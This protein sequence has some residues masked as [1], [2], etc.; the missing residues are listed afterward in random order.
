MENTGNVLTLH[1][2]CFTFQERLIS[3]PFEILATFTKEHKGM[4]VIGTGYA[5]SKHESL[6]ITKLN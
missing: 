5:N 6:F 4:G 2:E 3:M 1:R